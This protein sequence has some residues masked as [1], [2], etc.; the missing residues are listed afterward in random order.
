MSWSWLFWSK[1]NTVLF[2]YTGS[3]QFLGLF[4]GKFS[5]IVAYICSLDYL[6]PSVL[7]L[8]RGWGWGG[9]YYAYVGSSLPL[10]SPSLSLESF[11]SFSS[12]DFLFVFPLYTL[13]LFFYPRYSTCFC[14]LRR[15]ENHATLTTLPRSLLYLKDT[16]LLFFFLSHQISLFTKW[17]YL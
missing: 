5:L 14:H 8:C 3:S 1:H 11:W 2:K 17:K 16:L 6:L 4:S 12:T 10:F 13:F 9:A 7:V 15:L